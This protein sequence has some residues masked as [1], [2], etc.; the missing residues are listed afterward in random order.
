MPGTPTHI[1]AVGCSS[2]GP[3]CGG[4][5]RRPSRR[6]RTSTSARRKTSRSADVSTSS[7]VAISGRSCS[8]SP[9]CPSRRAIASAV[10]PPSAV[11]NVRQAPRATRSSTTSRCAPEPLRSAAEPSR[12]HHPHAERWRSARTA[13]RRRSDR[14]APPHEPSDPPRPRRRKRHGVPA[15]RA[16]GRSARGRSPTRAASRSGRV[17]PPRPPCPTATCVSVRR[18]DC[19]VA[20]SAGVA[21]PLAVSGTEGAGVGR[22]ALGDGQ[23][24]RGHATERSGRGVSTVRRPPGRMMSRWSRSGPSP[25]GARPG[26]TFGWPLPAGTR[27]QPRRLRRLGGPLDRREHR[28]TDHRSFGNDQALVRRS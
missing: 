6:V 3:S 23:E 12:S 14:A 4:R 24:H 11:R 17:G 16:S 7:V 15:R 22:D 27:A 18:S 2:S 25:P 8:A 20:R 21:N 13:G 1:V 19:F 5:K 9:V 10:S 26:T 28:S